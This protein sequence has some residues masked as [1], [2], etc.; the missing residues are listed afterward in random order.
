MEKELTEKRYY[1][2]VSSFALGKV[3]ISLRDDKEHVKDVC[4]SLE[5][6]DLLVSF[7]KQTPLK[8]RNMENE[9]KI[10]SV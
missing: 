10:H 3:L 4:V 9:V 8:F 1:V 5:D 2:R 7:S 6:D